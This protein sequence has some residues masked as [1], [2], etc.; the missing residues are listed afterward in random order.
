MT[1]DQNNIFAKISRGEIPCEKLYED[2]HT[3]AFM[4]I[5]PQADGHCLVIPKRPSTGLMDADPSVFASLFSSVQKLARAAQSGMQADGVTI[6]QFNGAAAGQTV[7]HLH[8]HILPRKDGVPL[9]AHSGQMEKSEIIKAH[10]AKIRA[11][12]SA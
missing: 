10:A 3:L 4:D 6:M 7:F 12:L 1:Y 8:V 11:A 5:M 2:D 9:K